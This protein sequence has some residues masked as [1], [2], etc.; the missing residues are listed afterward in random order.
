MECIDL[1]VE[2]NYEIYNLNFKLICREYSH[3]F[4]EQM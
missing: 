4:F 3:F 1:N 2:S